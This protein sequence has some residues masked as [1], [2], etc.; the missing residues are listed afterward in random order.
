MDAMRCAA[1]SDPPLL[2]A[3]VE[4]INGLLTQRSIP[5]Q[6]GFQAPAINHLEVAALSLPTFSSALFFLFRAFW[7]SFCRLESILI[8]RGSWFWYYFFRPLLSRWGYRCYHGATIRKKGT[9]ST[10]QEIVSVAMTPVGNM[11]VA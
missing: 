11:I 10:L 4:A 1:A 6:L 3:A 9:R 8:C 5:H 2:L 7:V